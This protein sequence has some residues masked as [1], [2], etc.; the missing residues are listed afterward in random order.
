MSQAMGLDLRVATPENVVLTYHLAG[1]M[2]RAGAY[3]IDFASR[4]MILL[5]LTFVLMIVAPFLPGLAIGS[6]LLVL[7]VLEWGY[8]IGFEYAW[9]GRTPGKW[10]MGLRVIQE[11]G[12]PLSWW[13][14]ALR[15][16]LRV[17]DTLPLLLVFPEDLGAFCLLPVY[18]P[19]FVA[20]LMTSRLQRLGDLA[21]RTVVV[22][23][24]RAELPREPVIFEKIEP[25][26]K[27]DFSAFTPRSRTL[28]LIDRFLG[29]RSVLLHD[30]GHALA[31]PLAAA[32]AERLGYTSDPD[33]VRKYPMAFLARVYVTFTAHRDADGAAEEEQAKPT[34][35]RRKARALR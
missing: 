29:R 16:L 30:R 27:A 28:S 34:R 33:L 7:F 35:K 26:S 14:S 32:L 11:N 1:P 8:T 5:G 24:R 9:S 4:V 12:Q 21:A 10:A 23:E 15:N 20:M 25:F 22:Q 13:G 6:L 18:G 17:A 3:V 19:G 31:S 2:L